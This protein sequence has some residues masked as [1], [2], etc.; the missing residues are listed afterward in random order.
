MESEYSKQDGS[1][2]SN[3]STNEV[4]VSA[5]YMMEAGPNTYKSAR[6]SDEPCE[7]QEAIVSEHASL[8]KNRVL[9]FVREIPA[10]K[11][12]IPSKHI[13]Q[14]KL[15][16]GGQ[17]VRFKAR[18]VAQRLCQVEGLDF[19]DTFAPVGSLSSV[20]VMFSIV[21]AKGLA[22][23]QIHVVTAFLG[24]EL[25]EEVYLSLPMGV[26][27]EERLACL[28]RS[29]YGL[30]QSP[31]CWYTTIDNFPITR[32]GFSRGRFDC[33]VYTHNNG[34]IRAL[35]VDNM[36]IAG[37]L[38][39][40]KLI[41]DILKGKFEIVDNGT[42]SLFLGMVVSM[43]T[44]GHMIS[45]TQ[46]GYIDWVL[47]RF[48]MTEWK[49]VGT[50]MEKD[51]PGMKGGGDKPYHRTL[52]LQLIGR[53]C[54]IAT[55]TRPDIA[56]TVSYL[57]RF[58]ADPDDRHW[59]CAKRFL[60]YLAGTKKLRLSQ[61][62]GMEA[63]VRLVE[64]VDSDF[65]GNAGTEKSTSGYVFLLGKGMIQ[66]HSKRQ[67]LTATSTADGEFIASASAIQEPVWF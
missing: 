49:P 61:G 23:C 13:L 6:E 19:T 56:F 37:A 40:V 5:V 42:V 60:R 11:K 44:G 8:E 47:E 33:C 34:M 1:R 16:P 3:T 43:D 48:D 45:L 9:T 39:E 66:W 63:G 28:N 38:G 7:W 31:R 21:A 54:W 20:C 55:G 58:N 27:G 53:L 12:A 51:K 50:P 29:L 2:T 26:F 57:W 62:G 46:E 25:Q 15:N 59:L 67:A 36:L 35:Y 65:T 52:H 32:M 30:K 4:M 18:L 10:T 22:V 14:K 17:T 41:C 64:F 24:S